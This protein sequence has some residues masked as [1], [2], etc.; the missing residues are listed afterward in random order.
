M[1]SERLIPRSAAR[2]RRS[3]LSSGL[4]RTDLMVE[5]PDPMVGLP[6]RRRMISSTSQPSPA[7]ATR[8]SR[9]L[10]TSALSSPPRVSRYL[11]VSRT[12]IAWIAHGP[13]GLSTTRSQEGFRADPVLGPRIG[14]SPLHHLRP[15]P[16]ARWRGLHPHLSRRA[17]GPRRGR[18]PRF[19]NTKSGWTR[20]RPESSI[21]ILNGR[22]RDRIPGVVS[23]SQFEAPLVDHIHI[24]SKKHRELELDAA[25]VREAG[26]TCHDHDEVDIA[27]LILGTICHR[28]EDVDGAFL[29]LSRDAPDRLSPTV[30]EVPETS[31]APRLATGC[32][33][34]QTML[35]PESIEVWTRRVSTRAAL[36][37]GPVGIGH[38]EVQF[39]DPRVVGPQ[40]L[41]DFALKA[42]RLDR[43]CLHHRTEVQPIL[44][45]VKECFEESE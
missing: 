21:G 35:L 30:D 40:H 28:F 15:L 41:D 37:G 22:R 17:S 3:L 36:G 24:D 10:L 19:C 11:Y 42:R 39:L 5:G 34:V 18:P 8:R 43:S 13:I 16:N 7:S 29:V 25:Q 38:E 2:R 6:A 44:V 27:V 14:S 4:N 31:H 33:E 9:S 20:R 1:A 32:C 12:F 26:S 23:I 45:A